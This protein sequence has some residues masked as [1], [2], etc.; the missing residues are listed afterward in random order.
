MGKICY[1]CATEKIN[2][3]CPNCYPSDI[4]ATPMDE[5]EE[6]KK[7]EVSYNVPHIPRPVLILEETV[8]KII[9]KLN[10]LGTMLKKE[11]QKKGLV[12]KGNVG[13]YHKGYL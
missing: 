12:A 4:R 6:L 13:T 2:G 7:I 10:E 8:N 5:N 11:K 3:I 1:D 9:D